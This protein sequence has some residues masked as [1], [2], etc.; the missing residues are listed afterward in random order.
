MRLRT[1]SY[2]VRPNHA[3]AGERVRGEP[4][5]TVAEARA[6]KPPL[7]TWATTVTKSEHSRTYARP[8]LISASW[9]YR[10]LLERHQ[11]Q[12]GPRMPQRRVTCA[13][14][15]LKTSTYL[16]SAARY[17]NHSDGDLR[18]CPGSH[19]LVLYVERQV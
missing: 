9:A 2:Y 11:L 12:R 6:S 17:G 3:V 8:E 10:K 15:G 13:W 4:T 5:R 18:N 1:G 7:P 14:C 16:Y 19:G